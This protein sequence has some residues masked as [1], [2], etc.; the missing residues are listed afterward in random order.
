MIGCK[1][2]LSVFNDPCLRI[3][4]KNFV[5][6]KRLKRKKIKKKKD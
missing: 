2:V 6:W 3:E 1:N 4:L 5:W